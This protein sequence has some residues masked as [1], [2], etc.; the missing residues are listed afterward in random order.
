MDDE[1]FFGKVLNHQTHDFVSDKNKREFEYPDVRMSINKTTRVDSLF[2]VCDL[3][4]STGID[5]PLT[6][7][8][9]QPG[10]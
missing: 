5:T 2:I 8:D 9:S 1:V 3:P 7:T 10:L 6:T 4:N